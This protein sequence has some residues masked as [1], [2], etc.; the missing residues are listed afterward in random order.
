[1]EQK[2]VMPTTDLAFRKLLGSN[3]SKPLLAGLLKE[4]YNTSVRPEE[5][6]IINPYSIKQF[7]N[8]TEDATET[9]R[10][11]LV[12]SQFVETK[13][14]ITCTII[15][16]ADFTIEMQVAHDRTFIKRILYYWA[17][18]YM[19]NYSKNNEGNKYA[20]LKPVWSLN[21]LDFNLFDDDDC[22]HLF[23]I[24]N[25]LKPHAPLP[26]P[27]SDIMTLG[28]FELNKDASANPAWQGWKEFLKTGQVPNYAPDYLKEAAKIIEY[29]NLSDQERKVIDA[30]TRRRDTAQAIWHDTID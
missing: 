29:Q 15:N 13:R 19:H 7:A 21:I 3:E 17:D 8:D 5:I 22:Y 30:E 6:S 25:H 26:L 14:D 10:Q 12:Q 23:N 9:T 28:F 27:L 11:P 4:F 20:S 18:L 24:R 2:I 16:T 1:M